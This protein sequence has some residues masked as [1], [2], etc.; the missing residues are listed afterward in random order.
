MFYEEQVQYA[1]PDQ[2]LKNKECQIAETKYEYQP[3]F[4]VSFSF[5]FISSSIFLLSVDPLLFLLRI[6]ER[7]ARDGAAAP[8][9]TDTAS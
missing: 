6:A 5:V 2:I 9:D 3:T 7:W 1:P 4:R 8:D